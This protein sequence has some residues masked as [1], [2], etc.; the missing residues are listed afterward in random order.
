MSKTHFKTER[1]KMACGKHID[2][3]KCF[4]YDVKEVDAEGEGCRNCMA[5]RAY[6]EQMNKVNPP[7]SLEDLIK[8][9]EA[10]TYFK[11]FQGMADLR[12]K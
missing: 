5:T 12:S 1:Y 9:P 6:K 2:D 11:P 7:S 3:T 10:P 4:A 8:Q